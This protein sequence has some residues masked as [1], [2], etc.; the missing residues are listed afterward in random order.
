M[1]VCNLPV[2]DRQ[3]RKYAGLS[4]E[5]PFIGL[6][7]PFSPRKNVNYLEILVIGEKMCDA[8]RLGWR[9]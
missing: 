6:R 5:T 7:N 1:I 2:Q 9:I 4:G 3:P 8:V